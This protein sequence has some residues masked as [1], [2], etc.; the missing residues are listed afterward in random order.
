MNTTDFDEEGCTRAKLPHMCNLIRN[1]CSELCETPNYKC[2]S[3]MH[4]YLGN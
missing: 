3:Q 2:D 4:L 1:S